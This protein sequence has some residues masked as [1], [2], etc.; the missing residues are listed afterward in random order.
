MK[1]ANGINVQRN[2][3]TRMIDR[4]L[5][6]IRSHVLARSPDAIFTRRNKSLEGEC[7]RGTQ[8][9]VTRAHTWKQRT[10]PRFFDSALTSA[11]SMRRNSNYLSLS[12]PQTQLVQ[13]AQWAQYPVEEIVM[14]DRRS[15]RG[16]ANRRYVFDRSQD[17]Y[18]LLI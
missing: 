18:K 14:R 8:T 1:F 9:Y 3:V 16:H 7:L 2:E 17:N 11:G 6:S 10:A 5:L 12:R 4:V 15:S 13:R